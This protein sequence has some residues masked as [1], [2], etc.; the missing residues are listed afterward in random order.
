M[1]SAL[2]TTRNVNEVFQCEGKWL[3]L[4]GRNLRSTYTHTHT[5]ASE[6]ASIW[7][8]INHF[9]V[10]V[11]SLKYIWLFKQEYYW[12]IVGFIYVEVK[13]DNE[14]QIWGLYVE[15]WAFQ[16]TPVAK[17]LPPNAGDIGDMG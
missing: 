7:V 6:V 15:V 5:E 16:V 11:I 14:N 17:N 1:S 13:Y 12:C 8:K 9:L 4:E 10:C 3:L 2:H